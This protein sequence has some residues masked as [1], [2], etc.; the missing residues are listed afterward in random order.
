VRTP[1][2]GP[3]AARALAA[4]P[5]ELRERDQWLLWREERR[6][7]QLTK[8]PVDPKT[9]RRASTTDPA[10]WGSWE[11]A[12][13]GSGG[14]AGIGFVFT[15]ADPFFGVDLDGCRDRATGALAPWAAEWIARFATYAEVS[16]SG[17]GV[18]LFGQGALPPGAWHKKAVAGEAARGEKPP[19][20]EVYD[21][22][23]FFTVTGQALTGT[24]ARLADGTGALRELQARFAP[25]ARPTPAPAGPP[26]A[27]LPLDDEAL[28]AKARAARNGLKFCRLF[29]G[30][31][32]SD[33]GGDESAADFA[34]VTC[35]AFYTDDAHQI[36]RLARRSAL[37]RP[38]WDEPR[39]GGTYLSYTISRAL[40][41]RTERYTPPRARPPREKSPRVPAAPPLAARPPVTAP[42]ARRG[43]QPRARRH[44]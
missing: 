14:A 16:P 8:V 31:D 17:T 6:G 3:G 34:L 38:K 41:S 5:P 37:G 22:A 39:P 28:L 44:L 18:K 7:G 32:P 1:E 23:R 9:G 40:Q 10:T 15:A 42:P 36:E 20:V 11:T 35:L 30:G 12:L 19:A 2:R 27:E 33:Y 29:D 24:P 43:E 25:P 13:A 21:R 26:P 4:V